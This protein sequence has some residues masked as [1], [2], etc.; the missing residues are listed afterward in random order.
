MAHIAAVDKAFERVNVGAVITRLQLDPG[1][2]G[3]PGD[4]IRPG[5]GVQHANLAHK[6][7][8]GGIEFG[9][10]Q[11]AHEDL[12]RKRSSIVEA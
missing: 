9:Q 8:Q 4:P 10:G 5:Q 6:A 2:L 12:L 1:Q 7:R 11:A 3:L